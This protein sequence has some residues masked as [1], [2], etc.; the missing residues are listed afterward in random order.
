MLAISA[1]GVAGVPESRGEAPIE[2]QVNTLAVIKGIVRDSGGSPIADATVAIFRA[3]TSKLLKQVNS[4]KDGSFI[5][6][7]MPGTYTVLAVA[8]GFNPE[9]FVVGTRH[10]I[11]AGVY[12]TEFFFQSNTKPT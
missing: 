8:E 7:I 1:T 11:Q 9:G 3:G 6:K 12:T 4:A 10:R 5:A 2:K